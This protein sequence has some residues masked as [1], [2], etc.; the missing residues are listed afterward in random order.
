MFPPLIRKA[1]KIHEKS[2]SRELLLY[3]RKY[4][5][6]TIMHQHMLLPAL[7]EHVL[8]MEEKT[9]KYLKKKTQISPLNII[10]K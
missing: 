5:K 6:D 1:M 9:Q 7:Q 8:R 4:I 3:G 10:S 2:Q